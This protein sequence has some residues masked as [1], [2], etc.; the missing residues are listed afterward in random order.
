[1]KTHFKVIAC[2]VSLLILVTAQS[3]V[4]Q[5]NLEGV[6]KVT[7]VTFTGPNARTITNLQPGLFIFTKKHYSVQAVTG[8]KPRPD[9][10]Q[11]NATDAQIAAAFRSFSANAG[12]YEIKGTTV[13]IR[14]MVAKN[15]NN[16][17]PGSFVTF[18]FKIDG[19]TLSLTPKVNTAGPIANP[20]TLKLVRLE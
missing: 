2:M 15:P 1:M 3:A 13:T 7:E 18:D 16:M 19:N 6:W 9:L 14:Q 5:A 10:P 17:K 4:A 12:T 8:E 11:E 20:L